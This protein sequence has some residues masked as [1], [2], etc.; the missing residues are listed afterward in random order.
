MLNPRKFLED[1]IRYG[2]MHF[3]GPL[4]WKAIDASI[5]QGSFL[6]ETSEK[7][8]WRFQ[9]RTGLA[10][11]SPSSASVAGLQCPRCSKEVDLPLTTCTS[12]VHW[13][14][15]NAGEKGFGFGDPGFRTE[16][17]F[18]SLQI[19]HDLLKTQKFRNDVQRLLE[20]TVPMPGTVLNTEGELKCIRA[21]LY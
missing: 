6:F 21:L 16:C 2:A 12:D 3:W 1:S 14:A 13:S 17:R 4:P 19:D 10:W 9:R 8:R 7:G 20:E 11:D 15:H 18:C 5:Y